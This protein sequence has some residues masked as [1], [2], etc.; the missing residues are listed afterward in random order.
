MRVTILVDITEKVIF[1]EEILMKTEWCRLHDF[2]L[3]RFPSW[4]VQL[5]CFQFLP[6]EKPVH[7][8]YD[9]EC[10]TTPGNTSC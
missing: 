8:S 6:A 4:P 3:V 10:I 9:P 1:T 7:S 5:I 2:Q